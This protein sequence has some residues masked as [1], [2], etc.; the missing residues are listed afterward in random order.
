[1]FDNN[2]NGFGSSISHSSNG[3]SSH[4]SSFGN[5]SISHHS[6]GSSSHTSSFG[7]SS[8]SHHSDG[9]FSHSTTTGNIT[10][11]ITFTNYFP[12]NI[13]YIT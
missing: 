3:I 7:D 12:K 1:M 13:P 11:S 4:T 10:S 8:F 6:D 9:S 2:D 5:S